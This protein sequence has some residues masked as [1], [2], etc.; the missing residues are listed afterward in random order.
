MLTRRHIRVKV[1]QAI[2][3]YNQNK[4]LSLRQI[5]K[6]LK[7]SISQLQDL[8]VLQLQLFVE[9]RKYAET[10]KNQSKKRLSSLPKNQTLSPNFANNKLLLLI[11]SN[12]DLSE[13]LKNKKL[14]YWELDSEFV[15]LFYE[16]LLEQEWFVDYQNLKE[17]SYKDDKNIVAR[18]LKEIVAPSDKLY[19][20]LEDRELTWLDDFPIVN[21]TLLR[22]FNKLK[23]SNFASQLIPDL[24][25]SKDDEVFAYSLLEKVISNDEELSKEIE[26]KTP[27]WD[28]DRIAVLDA[29]ILKMGITEFISFP[30]I[31]VRVTI[32][33]YL[34]IAK[35]YSTSRSSLFINGILDKL[36]KEYEKES[37]L[38]KTGRGLI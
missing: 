21:T 8:Y 7:Q 13:I 24:Y 29:I 27:N 36:A 32:N 3:F 10:H 15:Q 31:P 16:E 2:Y 14:N 5:E 18:I 17:P 26:G 22:V 30:T 11:E 37:K 20:Y 34:E 19:Q 9:L 4:H 12:E 23:P 33:E 6:F 38:Q 28:K 1:M 25:K 35:E